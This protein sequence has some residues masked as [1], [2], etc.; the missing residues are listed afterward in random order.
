MG[1]LMKRAKIYL[2]LHLLLAL[3]SISSVLS[4]LAAGEP[5]LSPRFCLCYLGIIA[6]L[7]I[8]AIGWQQI[9]KR[10]PLTSAYANKAAS[11]VW[12]FIWGILFFQEQMTIGKLAGLLMIVAG[13][14]LYAY[15]DQEGADE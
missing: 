8:Y 4:K 10:I 6:L 3:Y 12:G 9:I 7:G 1:N 11:V 5:F 14:V 15:A 2:F 13:I